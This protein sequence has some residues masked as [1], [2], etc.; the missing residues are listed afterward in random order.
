MVNP[1]DVD[2][3]GQKEKKETIYVMERSR[4]I[5]RSLVIETRRTLIRFLLVSRRI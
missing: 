5:M 4:R 1:G 2:W 3:A